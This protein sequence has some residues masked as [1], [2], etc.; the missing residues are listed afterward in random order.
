M[1]Q[2]KQATAFQGV[3]DL[4]SIITQAIALR[5]AIEGFLDRYNS[6][7]YNTI[8]SNLP[9]AAQ[10]ADGSIGSADASPVLTHPITANNIFRSEA[11]LLAGVTFCQDFQ[12]FL[13]NQA[14]STA[15]R[16]QSLDDLVD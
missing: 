6:E 3:T 1:P 5:V 2:T 4:V 8:W 12:K 7:G 13:N 11:S 15:Q 9:T 16:S 10:N 14:V